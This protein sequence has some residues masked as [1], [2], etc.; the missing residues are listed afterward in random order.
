VQHQ[1][2]WSFGEIEA[3]GINVSGLSQSARLAHISESIAP[4]KRV[5]NRMIAGGGI[6]GDNYVGHSRLTSVD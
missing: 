4:A 6:V 3:T 1:Y 5:N 2:P